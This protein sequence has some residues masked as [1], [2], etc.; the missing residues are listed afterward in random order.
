MN[1]VERT[2]RPHV[3]FGYDGTRENDAALRWA[4]EEARLRDLDLVICHCWHWPYAS[5]HEDP[6]AEAI[7][8]RAGENLLAQGVRRA[9]ELGAPETVRRLL[10]RG[11]VTEA[12]LEASAAAEL[13]VIGASERPDDGATALELPAR[14][15]CPVIVVP[16]AAAPAPR[17]VAGTDAAEG[18]AA[19]LEYA[20]GE[21]ALRGWELH[22]VYGC[23]EPAAVSERELSLFTDVEL[24]EKTRTAELEEVVEPWRE[25][26]PDVE[27]TTSLLLERPC[28]ALREAV[29]DAG[30]LVLGNRGRSLEPLGGTSSEMLRVCSLPVAV[31]PGLRSRG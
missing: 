29:A 7:R 4:V 5:A 26:R 19:V 30:L 27:V 28:E 15:E 24:L 9:R 3:L 25:R 17:V 14:A 21:A 22:V 12:L 8:Q 11:P 13:T 16:D 1:G 23:W 31:V 20:F 18:C 10:L 6:Y 2:R